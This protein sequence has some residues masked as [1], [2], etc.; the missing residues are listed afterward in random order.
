MCGLTGFFYP[1]GFHL[2]DATNL[3]QQMA[4]TLS[5]RGPDDGGLRSLVKYFYHQAHHGR[6]TCTG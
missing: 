3:A 1:G 4:K 5:H 6:C 2:E